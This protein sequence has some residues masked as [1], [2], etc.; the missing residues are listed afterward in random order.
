M[1]SEIAQG[2]PPKLLDSYTTSV[3]D[4]LDLGIITPAAFLSGVLVL[5][6]AAA[7]Y[8]MAFPLL[9][10]IVILAPAIAAS[11]VSQLSAGVSFSTGEIVGPIAGFTILGVLAI[12]FLIGLLRNLHEGG[13]L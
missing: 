3:T 4:V 1:V 8:L 5:R 9:G 12:W 11:T 10:I 2:Q 6:R 7:G 13:S